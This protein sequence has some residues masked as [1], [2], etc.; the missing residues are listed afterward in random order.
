LRSSPA[1]LSTL[2]SLVT[3]SSPSPIS[4]SFLH[5]S[6][7]RDVLFVFM[8]IS[9]AGL[10]CLSFRVHFAELVATMLG[11]GVVR[12]CLCALLFSAVILI[13]GQFFRICIL[14]ISF[15]CAYNFFYSRCRINPYFKP[16]YVLSSYFLAYLTNPSES[17]FRAYLTEQS[18]RQHLSR[19]DDNNEDGLGAGLGTSKSR[20]F[21]SRNGS[22]PDQ[23]LPPFHFADRASIS[24]RTPK[25]VFHSF[26]V[27][28][29]AAMI[30]ATKSDGPT[31]ARSLYRDGSAISDSWYIGAFGKWWRGGI[32][33]AWYQDVIARSK[34]EES[35]SSGILAMKAL[36]KLN[37]CNGQCIKRTHTLA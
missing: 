15:S 37:D 20:H 34:D 25:H 17:S 3:P 22:I 13:L 33:E 24:L 16:L 12:S 35:W 31:S 6:N 4:P 14:C 1:T 11:K 30:P 26:G 32:V 5:L 23:P 8:G 28:T 19:L 29:I 2:L 21:A 18:F 10:A 9:I 7:R 27:F 36:D